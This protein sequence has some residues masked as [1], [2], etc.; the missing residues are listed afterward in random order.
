MKQDVSVS[1]FL[2][3]EIKRAPKTPS[4]KAPAVKAQCEVVAV[5]PDREAESSGRG[6]GASAPKKGAY[7]LHKDFKAYRPLIERLKTSAELSTKAGSACLV[8]FGGVIGAEH[9]LVVGTGSEKSGINALGSA[10]R[11]RRL[12]AHVAHKLAAEK[13]RDAVVYLDSFLLPASRLALDPATAAY[14]FIEGMGLASYKFKKYFK[15]SEKDEKDEA[16]SITLASTEPS[17]ASGY[18]KGLALARA[19][20]H[21]AVICRDLGNEPSNV[22]YPEEFAERAREIAAVHGLK[23]TVLDEKGILEERMGLLAGVGQ[24]SVKPPRLIVLEYDPPKRPGRKAP[25]TIAF[26]GKGITFD[27]GGISI[28]PSTRMEDMKHDMCGAAAV[29]GAIVAASA[30]KLNTRILTVVAAAENM[31]SGSAIQPGN[32]LRSR[33]G[34]TVEIVNTDAEGRLVLADALDY[35]QDSKP[36]YII[37]LATLTGAATITL[38]KVCS[39]LMGNDAAFNRMIQAAAR[40]SGERV[41]E[42]PLFEEYFDDL[43]SE[44]ADMRNSGDSPAN[45][46]AKG[47]MFL[48]EYIRKG[49]RWAHLDIA[50]VAYAAPFAPYYPKKASSGYGVRLLVELARKMG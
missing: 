22:L 5:A 16:L 35:I 17:R 34:K 18:M 40:E 25:K 36:D 46:T 27:S 42:L 14:A 20:L 38:G 23:C 24:G 43:K 9:A 26:V 41:W 2:K 48:Y 32:I 45:G 29:V 33:N 31:P 7:S 3:V 8:R 12:G 49:T 4:H 50:S 28:K 13:I 10:E 37:D 21:G 11:L 1:N 6:Q 19:L 15:K 30:L 47:A 44:F 39:G